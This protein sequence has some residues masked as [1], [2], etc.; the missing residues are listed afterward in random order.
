MDLKAR[1]DVNCERKDGQTD[2]RKTGRLCHTLRKQEPNHS[3]EK[4]LIDLLSAVSGAILDSRL[5]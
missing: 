4:V 3:G 2:E 5:G 1:I